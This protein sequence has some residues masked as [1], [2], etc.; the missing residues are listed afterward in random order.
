MLRDQG[1]QAE[2]HWLQNP[3]QTNWGNVNNLRRELVEFAGTKEG[4]LERKVIEF[5]ENSRTRYQGW[6][7]AMFR[8]NNNSPCSAIFVRKSIAIASTF[9][10]TSA[11]KKEAACCSNRR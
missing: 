4:I 2:L 9:S 8:T 11:M 1:K 5:K 3:S 6:S 7:L 10:L